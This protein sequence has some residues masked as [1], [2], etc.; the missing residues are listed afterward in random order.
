VKDIKTNISGDKHSKFFV[1]ALI[2][3]AILFGYFGVYKFSD[4]LDS[5]YLQGALFTQTI[6]GTGISLQFE[7]IL[8]IT[9][10]G[11][12]GHE[13]DGEACI[14]MPIKFNGTTTEEL[15]FLSFEFYDV[16]AYI[17][18]AWVKK[19]PANSY[20]EP[21]PFTGNDYQNTNSGSYLSLNNIYLNVPAGTTLN[22]IEIGRI[23]FNIESMAQVP[24]SNFTFNL[25]SIALENTSGPVYYDLWGN[26]HQVT[27]SVTSVPE[28]PSITNVDPS[29]TTIDIEW[30][31]AGGGDDP[32]SYE[33]YRDETLVQTVSASASTYTYSNLTPNLSYTLGIKAINSAGSSAMATS[34]EMTLPNPVTDFN[35][36]NIQ[37]TS[38][39]LNWTAPSPGGA[40]DYYITGTGGLSTVVASPN[41]TTIFNNLTPSNS[42]TF[43][44][45]ARNSNGGAS[46]PMNITATTEAGFS[47]SS[48]TL[49]GALTPAGP[50]PMPVPNEFY[51]KAGNNITANVIIDPPSGGYDIDYVWAW[52]IPELANANQ[53]TTFFNINE[54]TN[55]YFENAQVQLTV[56]VS[57]GAGTPE[58]STVQF[59]IIDN[60]PVFGTPN[61]VTTWSGNSGILG[62]TLTFK[63]DEQSN[64]NFTYTEAPGE[65]SQPSVGWECE[66][67]TIQSP[68]VNGTGASGSIILPLKALNDEVTRPASPGFTPIVPPHSCTFTYIPVSGGGDVVT[69]TIPI[70]IANVNDQPTITGPFSFLFS[71]DG[72]DEPAQY[73][74]GE[75][76][77]FDL[78]GV[79]ET[80]TW[81]VV[82][83]GL[84]SGSLWG[85]LSL[86]T[87]DVSD[88]VATLEWVSDYPAQG[89][90][91][92]LTLPIR[93]KDSQNLYSAN[94]DLIL[95]VS[96]DNYPPI[97]VT[98]PPLVYAN[99]NEDTIYS[100]T[101]DPNDPQYFEDLNN[102]TLQ[103]QINE[104]SQTGISSA[105]VNSETGLFTIIPKADFN[106]TA[107]NYQTVIAKVCD[108]ESACTTNLTFQ[109]AWQAVNDAPI[110]N[111]TGFNTYVNSFNPLYEEVGMTLNLS[112]YAEDIDSPNLTWSVDFGD[113][114]EKGYSAD[115]IN[116]LDTQLVITP[117]NQTQIQ[118]TP[119]SNW[120]GVVP[121]VATVSDG[122]LEDSIDF[123]FSWLQVPDN[124]VWEN[125]PGKNGQVPTVKYGGTYTF[126]LTD[127]ISDSDFDII[128]NQALQALQYSEDTT[129]QLPTS[130][131]LPPSQSNIVIQSGDKVYSLVVETTGSAYTFGVYNFNVTATG[132]DNLVAS[133]SFSLDIQKGDMQ[134]QNISVINSNLLEVE[135]NTSLTNSQVQGGLYSITPALNITN[136]VLKSG[137]PNII[138]ITTAT[139]TLGQSYELEVTDLES[140]FYTAGIDGI[141]ANFTGYD[142][143]IVYDMVISAVVPLSTNSIKVTMS[144]P[145]SQDSIQSANMMLS[146]GASINS[147]TFNSGSEFTLNTSQLAGSTDYT[148]TVSNL[149]F[150]NHSTLGAQEYVFTSLPPNPVYDLNLLSALSVNNTTVDLTFNKNIQAQSIQ[151]TDFSIPGLTVSAATL[152]ANQSIIRLTTT[153]QS[154][155]LYTVTVSGLLTA[156]DGGLINT[157]QNSETFTGTPQSEI[158][159]GDCDDNGAL[160]LNDVLLALNA[161]VSS[162]PPPVNSPVVLNCSLSQIAVNMNDVLAVYAEYIANK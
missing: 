57:Q 98:P 135:L 118:I 51:A 131:N 127:N 55:D 67:L 86:N 108:P 21:D 144:H 155:A 41:T 52:N 12:E 136:K 60:P 17:N 62:T 130:G 91:G 107:T 120:N 58:T 22:E 147:K 33:L 94:Y 125:W 156:T 143:G 38:V 72:D 137:Y 123:E 121:F 74:Y 11:C 119:P 47:I 77:D 56:S 112:N 138:Q 128:K 117:L 88:E 113:L 29:T 101:I 157:E 152:Q 96:A 23:Y 25:V 49:S 28:I 129:F 59:F 66:G 54:R 45:V 63:Q 9:Q 20:M 14:M 145:V 7:D 141:T 4:Y 31:G 50:T 3:L 8:T 149:T 64:L 124:P 6:P 2:C 100:F 18:K 48:I 139:Q 71:G 146:G 30:E 36:T 133:K 116:M 53:V 10:G 151:P 44:I 69:K 103:W 140:N 97:I 1:G 95:S 79:S 26:P 24:L 114:Q 83:P 76:V 122:Y 89:Q 78:P 61:Y 158:L 15:L 80:M 102:D 40:H 16:P 82:T 162:P 126:N 154:S 13:S 85:N 43:T 46:A 5:S 159:F 160:L 132:S 106:N 75:D 148:L 92:N 35:A 109:F 104:F 68:T 161:L 110:I 65:T 73:V 153:S 93:V 90:S 111:E 32:T 99:Q 84:L 81:E 115:V 27:V 70:H 37:S 34:T 134:I 19:N 42:Y 39:Q 150:N 105:T 142:P 87:G